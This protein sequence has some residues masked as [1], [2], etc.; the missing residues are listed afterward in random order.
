MCGIAGWLGA[1]PDGE[2]HAWRVAETLRHRGPDAQAVRAWPDATLIHTRLS[3]IDLS[4]AGAQP[5]GNEDGTIWTVFNGE[6]YNHK[7]LRRFLEQKGHRLEG[8]SDTEVIPHLYEEEGPDFLRRLR[9]MFALAVYDRKSRFLMLARDRFGIKPVFYA[10]GRHYLAFA[11]ELRALLELPDVDQR[12]NPQ[13]IYDFAALFYIPAPETFYAGIRALE[14]GELLEAEFDSERVRWQTRR[15]H[16][17]TIARDFGISLKQAVQKADELVTT[18]VRRQIESDVPLGALLSG[19]ID[20]SLVSAAAQQA[21]KGQL[22]TFNVQFSEAEYDETWAAAAVAK[23]IGSRHDILQMEQGQGTWDHVTA[24]LLHAGQPFADTSLFAVNAVCR[25]MRQHVTVALSGDGGD[26]AFS[27][28]GIYWRLARIARYK[29]IPPIFLRAA[30]SV[31][32]PLALLGTVPGWWPARMNRLAGADETTLIQSLF[33]LMPDGLQEALCGPTNLLPIRRFFESQWDHRIVPG[34]SRLERLAALA[35][36]ANIRLMLPNDFL[37]KVD[38]ASMKE[39]LE[40]RVPMLDE[41]LFDFGISLPYQLNVSGRVCKRVLRE[42]AEA[43]LP[44]EVAVKPKQGFGIPLDSWV[45]AEF[46]A[47]LQETILGSES[48]LPDFFRPEFYRPRVEAFVQGRSYQREPRDFLYQLAIM[49]LSVHLALASKGRV[50]L[51]M[52]KK[53]AV[54][55]S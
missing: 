13:A 55:G 24:L 23:H 16:R 31:L 37:F 22:Q 36:E 28:Y 20:S 11:S 18:A 45:N 51:A 30:A 38:T 14:P 50:K 44:R 12:P 26:E 1:L 43:K 8:R 32:A 21:L 53:A 35:A 29:D 41:D 3:I 10:T 6:I 52:P 7:E 49:L 33:C 46:K 17:W 27:G 4:P 25:S 9:G 47:R 39:S 19:G 5:M 48:R 34:A 40:I 2:E 15:F 42:I 54:G